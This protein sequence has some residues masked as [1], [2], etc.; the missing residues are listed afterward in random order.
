MIGIK[1]PIEVFTSIYNNDLASKMKIKLTEMNI[2]NIKHNLEL[3]KKKKEKAADKSN[4]EEPKPSEVEILQ[5][6]MKDA[7]EISKSEKNDVA[8]VTASFDF[9]KEVLEL[10]PKQ[11]KTAKKSVDALEL[12]IFLYYLIARIQ[13]APDFDPSVSVDDE[14]NKD[15]ED[16]K[17]D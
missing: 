12:S 8:F 6:Q 2:Q 14:S 17:K 7:E 11:L 4:T 16:P 3:A 15:D 1:E 5:E 13:G 9:I 10:N